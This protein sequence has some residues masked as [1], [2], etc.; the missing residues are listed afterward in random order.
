MKI[1]VLQ[2][3]RIGDLILTTPALAAL[4]ENLPDARITLVVENA[5]CE[6]LPA[7]D[8]VD[9]T[10]VYNRAGCNGPLWRKLVFRS[11]DVCLDFTGSDRSALFAV[12]SKSTKRVAFEW[13]Q[14]SR[15][16]PIFYN[17]FV[18]SSVRENH[19]V[20]HYGHMLRALHLVPRQ[21]A[22]AL[23]LPEWAEKKAR[24]LLA[25]CGVEEGA[26]FALVHPGTARPEKYWP[27]ERWAEIV[28]WCERE[29]QI[30]CVLTGSADV[31][32]QQH[33]SKI[34]AALAQPARDLSGRT[35]LL[36]LAALAKL[37]RLVLSVDSAA[38]HLAAAFSTPQL[39]LFGPTNPFHWR[40]RHAH[41]VLLLA[42]DPA[43]PNPPLTP[44]HESAPMSELSTEHVKS[45]IAEHLFA[46]GRAAKNP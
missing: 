22:I 25:G 12:L 2:L 45:A 9:E 42:S 34:K 20:D 18:A 32:E 33:I 4:R 23:H 15:G 14:R 36:T 13:L 26:A 16:K 10:L 8:F 3:K 24:Q 27:P 46:H 41:S 43:H 1:L 5:C 28:N 35:D 7:L 19:T 44:H 38:M 6:L 37:A 31:A 39:A 17:S 21:P 29:W 30:P 11:F 40:P